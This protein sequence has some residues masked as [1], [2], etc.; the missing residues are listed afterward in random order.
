[1]DTIPH[2]EHDKTS[3]QRLAN[4]PWHD[5]SEEEKNLVVLLIW[6]GLIGNSVYKDNQFFVGEL[7]TPQNA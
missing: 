4:Q 1:M 7:L 5:L 6:K 2:S 3:A